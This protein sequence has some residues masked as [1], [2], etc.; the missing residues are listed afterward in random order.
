MAFAIHPFA[1]CGLLT[2]V[3]SPC[4]GA[5]LVWSVCGPVFVF[6]CGSFW[7]LGFVVQVGDVGLAIEVAR[8]NC[9]HLALL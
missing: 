9:E 4:L 1:A 7:G 3:S 2:F 8:E 6:C 5:V